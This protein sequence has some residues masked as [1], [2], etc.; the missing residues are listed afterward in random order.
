MD[1]QEDQTKFVFD[2]WF[3]VASV[4][5]SVIG[6]ITNV[7]SF[8]RIWKTF[9]TSK[10]LYLI[11][12]LDAGLTVL[13]FALTAIVAAVFLMYPGSVQN[14]IGCNFYN[15]GQ[16]TIGI[17][18]TFLLSLISIVRYRIVKS[19]ASAWQNRFRTA[20]VLG[21]A[22]LG[23]VYSLVY[24]AMGNYF[25]LAFL[26][27]VEY[28]MNGDNARK[29]SKFIILVAIPDV[30]A[31][32]YPAIFDC[33]TYYAIK[34]DINIT[35]LPSAQSQPRPPAAS[36]SSRPP[37]SIAWDST[38][39]PTPEAGQQWKSRRQMSIERKRLQQRQE[40]LEVP[41]RATILST[42]LGLPFIFFGIMAANIQWPVKV[43]AHLY[44]FIAL[45]LGIVRNPI[46]VI[47]TFKSN[48]SNKAAT[49]EV[50]RELK[51][52]KVISRALKNRSNLAANNKRIAPEED[53][54]QE[55]QQL[56]VQ[57]LQELSTIAELEVESE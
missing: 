47:M 19:G 7:Y 22:I 28:C 37:A 1:G 20:V 49:R 54:G 21:I 46:M 10:A 27:T 39:T 31:G 38:S 30:S 53:A 41:L 34:K 50:D 44:F 16:F 57:G 55:L 51:R 32:I 11:L 35:A 3:I 29:S 17:Y 43:K 56:N 6:T 4:I 15:F 25:D 18:C 24:L 2:Q 33:L 12:A 42:I 23:F 8:V 48:E 26:N 14:R 9:D 5:L 52:Q 45:A 13:V 40:L 36:S